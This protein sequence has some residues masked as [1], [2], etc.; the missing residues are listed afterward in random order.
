MNLQEQDSSYSCCTN[1][2]NN[3]KLQIQDTFDGD[4]TA[5]SGLSMKERDLALEELHGVAGEIEETPEMVSRA[6]IDMRHELSKVSSKK[7]KFI[8]R[9]IF[10]CPSLANDDKL[11]LK[12]LR[13]ERFD[14]KEA[15]QKMCIHYDNKAELFPVHKLPCPITLDDMDE[16]DMACFRNGNFQPLRYKD[17]AGRTVNV[18]NFA[19]VNYKH[20]K[21]E[22]C[23]SREWNIVASCAF[24]HLANVFNYRPGSLLGS[25]LLVSSPSNV[26][27]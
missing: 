21:N 3:K 27:R 19:K 7:R 18:L 6:L 23:H 16:D 22:V 4:L 12:F 17:Q 25:I 2:S 14:A 9:A 8:D 10:L 1:G 13:G 24:P 5:F 26:G 15:A 20:W 11:L